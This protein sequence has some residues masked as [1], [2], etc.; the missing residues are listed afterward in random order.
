MEYAN[1]F[2]QEEPE[3]HIK[4]QL[5]LFEQAPQRPKLLDEPKSTEMSPKTKAVLDLIYKYRE[6]EDKDI[7]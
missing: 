1:R 4:P 7:K 2:S 3:V 5:S 6:L